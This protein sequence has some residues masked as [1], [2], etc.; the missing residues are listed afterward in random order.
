M[1][2]NPY[3]WNKVNANLFYGHAREQLLNELFKGL[4]SDLG[5]TNFS[6]AIAGARRMGKTTLLRR[7]EMKLQQHLATWRKGGKLVIPI[8][9]DGQTLPDVLTDTYLWGYL[10]RELKKVIHQ[11]PVAPDLM[12]FQDFRENMIRVLHQLDDIPRIIVMFD[13]IELIMGCPWAYTFLSNWRA[14]LSNTPKVSEYFTIVLAGARES[15][16]L[17]RDLGS[18]LANV[19]ELRSLQNLTFADA[20]KIMEEPIAHP[21]S[22]SFKQLVFKETGG[23]PMLLQY[24]MQQVCARINQTDW[25]PEQSVEQAIK[26]FLTLP[27]LAI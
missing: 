20:G 21:W 14:L 23:H 9:I 4:S 6:F 25:L 8:Y 17:K 19:I 15:S 1:N 24:L 26:D 3:I 2:N 22:D 10:F 18:P 27:S 13:E 11:L 7:L 5:S 16:A 12:N